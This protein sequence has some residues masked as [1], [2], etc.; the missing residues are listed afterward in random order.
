LT[1]SRNNATSVGATLLAMPDDNGKFEDRPA[2][3]QPAALVVDPQLRYRDPLA[4]LVAK[5]GLV[6]VGA[7]AVLVYGI[8]EKFA[9]PIWRGY[10]DFGREL[11][12]WRPD[13]EALVSGFLFV[14]T[15][16]I[17]YAW[18][19]WGI[20]RVFADFA[21][22]ESFADK[23]A[24][25]EF[26]T[27]ANVWFSRNRWWPV[28][29]VAAMVGILVQRLYLWDDHN[30]RP[31]PPWFNEGRPLSMI[32]ALALAPLVWYAATQVIIGWVRLAWMLRSLWRSLGHSFVLRARQH[33]SGVASLTRHIAILTT[34]GAVVFLNVVVG[35]LLP[36]IRDAEASPDFQQWLI[37]IW[38]VY[39][40][41]IPTLALALVW[42]AHRVMARKK[43]ER[44][45]AIT[46]EINKE[47]HLVESN[48]ADGAALEASMERIERLR[49]L[50][51][52]LQAEL[53]SWPLPRPL[54]AVSWS[55]V[56]PILLT[57]LTAT[58][59]RVA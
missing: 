16:L 9:L 43:N 23:A 12:T 11:H 52:L 36:Q 14:P 45:N 35:A 15:I 13:P 27:K 38:A 7:L 53:P 22:A 48:I 59:D 42:P 50:K 5:L 32:V 46:A 28:A 8:G 24:F 57:I 1:V 51:L 58:L 17:A 56:V 10:F 49:R 29:L 33:D 25:A 34:V 3:G 20:R 2:A 44:L 54:R 19:I 37:I 55:A 26:L 30:P 47:L 41:T 40:V 21:R 18:Q 4:S 39:L 6:W 31:V